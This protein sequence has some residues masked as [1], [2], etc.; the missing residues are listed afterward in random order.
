MPLPRPAA[1]VVE[2]LGARGILAMA[3]QW[4]GMPSAL[5]VS[6]GTADDTDAVL[7]A[8]A[9]LIRPRTWPGFGR[10]YT[11]SAEVISFAAK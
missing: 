6:V 5:R 1:E 2:G 10:D 3:L 4:T 11:R 9:A 8:L 7:A